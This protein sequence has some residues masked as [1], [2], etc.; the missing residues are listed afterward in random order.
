[1]RKLTKLASNCLQILHFLKS[2]TVAFINLKFQLFMFI[3]KKFELL[4][5]K[6][7]EVIWGTKK[8]QKKNSLNKN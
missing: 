7:S 5:K 3:W 2:F 4:P 6:L 8:F 1:M